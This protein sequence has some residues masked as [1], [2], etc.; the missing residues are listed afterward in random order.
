MVCA[1]VMIILVA[2]VVVAGA[3]VVVVGVV[4]IIVV[5]IIVVWSQASLQAAQHLAATAC[6]M[7]RGGRQPY[8]PRRNVPCALYL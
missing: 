6:A 8:W 4:V 3:L 2:A 1:I 7:P 5:V